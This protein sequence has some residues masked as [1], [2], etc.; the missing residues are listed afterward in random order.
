M[1]TILLKRILMIFIA[2]AGLVACEGPEGP[3]GPQGP[4]RHRSW[5]LPVLGQSS[6]NGEQMSV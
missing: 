1:K 2:I 3:A 4:R 6:S 5:E